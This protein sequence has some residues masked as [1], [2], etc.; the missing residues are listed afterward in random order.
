MVNHCP[1]RG[2]TGIQ[3]A[4]V[5]PEAC[6][7]CRG[8]RRNPRDYIS[9]GPR[10]LSYAGAPVGGVIVVESVADSWATGSLG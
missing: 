2:G 1:G 3:R 10:L 8:P 9:I 4:A 6:S 7:R 5:L